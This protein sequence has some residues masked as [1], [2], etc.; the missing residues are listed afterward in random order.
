MGGEDFMRIISIV[1]Q[2]GG[3]GKTSTAINLA[4]CLAIMRR[5]VLLLDLDPQAHASIGL[6]IKI[7]ELEKCIYHALVGGDEVGL[8]DISQPIS[9]NL[10]L[11]PSHTMLSA[12]EQK[13]ALV[14]RREDRLRNCIDQMVQRYHYI[15]ID[16]PP[17]IGVLTVNALNACY[18]VIVPVEPSVFSLQGLAKLMET[19]NLVERKRNHKIRI[20]ALATI[21]DA[22][23]RF[24]REVLENIKQYFKERVFDTCIRSSVRLREAAS[25]GCPVIVHD[26]KSAVAEDYMRLTTEVINEEKAVSV[27]SG[28]KE[29]TLT[30]EAPT[31][32]IVQIVGDFNNWSM[33]QN[34]LIKNHKGIWDISFQLRSGRYEYKYIID[35]KWHID[36]KNPDT[37][38]NSYGGI[39]SVLEVE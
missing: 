9:R 23:T 27:L 19:I 15:I 11:V 21:Y 36:P 32:K 1:N 8:E 16:C 30:V 31:A 10:D 7:D 24:A 35:G 14:D 37:V 20:K 13:L 34:L 38:Q 39:N 2:K 33:D 12:L 18:E 5:R 4:A 29:V 22:R 25:Y 28:Y 26:K 3:C 17:N 6:N